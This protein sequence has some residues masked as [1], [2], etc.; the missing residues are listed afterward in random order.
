M[1]SF[2][3]TVCASLTLLFLGGTS[4]RS[5]AQPDIFS[6]SDLEIFELDLTFVAGCSDIQVLEDFLAREIAAGAFSSNVVDTS[7]L[8]KECIVLEIPPEKSVPAWMRF[9]SSYTD[10]ITIVE[11][12]FTLDEQQTHL[13]S[14]E[15]LNGL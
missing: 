12:I 7:R 14:F 8:P 15:L 4:D 1:Y 11:V 5:F 9:Y 10:Y 3:T 13:Y 2:R 6:Q